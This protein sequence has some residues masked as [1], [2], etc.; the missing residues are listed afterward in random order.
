MAAPE[1]DSE[2]R[3][4]TADAPIATIPGYNC[5]A[6]KITEVQSKGLVISSVWKFARAMHQIDKGLA[7]KFHRPEIGTPF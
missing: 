3:H 7:S 5:S 1:R 6:I 2:A 4:L